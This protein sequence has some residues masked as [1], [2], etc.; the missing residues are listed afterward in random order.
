MARRKKKERAEELRGM[1]DEDLTKELNES[2]RRL[3]TVRLQ[4]STRQQT[5][6]TEE[7]KVRRQI[8]RIRTLQRERELAA[9]YASPAATSATASAARTGR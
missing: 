9:A 8:A 1:S 3:F 7:G 2:Y 5:N 4:T 6:T